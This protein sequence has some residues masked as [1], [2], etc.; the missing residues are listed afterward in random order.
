MAR[1]KPQKAVIVTRD[2]TRKDKK[3]SDALQE[4]M[5]SMGIDTE[6]TSKFDE[7]VALANDNDADFYH[8]QYYLNLASVLPSISLDADPLD[9]VIYIIKDLAVKECAQRF[10]KHSYPTLTHLQA[11]NKAQDMLPIISDITGRDPGDVD[12]AALIVCIM[13][14]KDSLYS[15]AEGLPFTPDIY[16]LSSRT[17]KT[18]SF[19]SLYPAVAKENQFTAAD[20]TKSKNKYTTPKKTDFYDV[21]EKVSSTVEKE[22]MDMDEEASDLLMQGYNLK[23]VIT[24]H[25]QAPQGY[26]ETVSKIMDSEPDTNFDEIY[27]RLEPQFEFH[28]DDRQQLI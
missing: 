4:W 17:K 9:R 3:C 24:F 1:Y 14:G 28:P 15:I 6:D 18:S 23:E 22:Y 2:D 13:A 5:S 11:K 12:P 7:V 8:M 21:G 10:I 20:Y 26:W 27:A 16:E 25:N 19:S